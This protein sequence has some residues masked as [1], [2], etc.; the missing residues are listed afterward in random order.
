M[1]GMVYFLSKSTAYH[2]VT[3]NEN[4]YPQVRSNRSGKLTFAAEKHKFAT[5]Q[6]AK[7]PAWLFRWMYSSD[8]QKY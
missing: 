3:V 5:Q 1:K 8:L 2:T 4:N 7:S 6:M